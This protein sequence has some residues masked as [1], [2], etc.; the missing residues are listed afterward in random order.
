M[1]TPMVSVIIPTFGRLNLLRRAIRSVFSQSYQNFEIIIVDDGPMNNYKSLF[2]EFCDKRLQYFNRRRKGGVASAR[3]FGIKVSSGEFIAFLDDDDEWLPSK[4]EKQVALLQK[5]N[6]R[7]GIVHTNCYI[8]NGQEL[9][10]F[11]RRYL[12]DQSFEKLLEHDFIANSTCLIRREC[13]DVVGYFDEKIPY[14]EDWEFFIRAS[15][16]C[17]FAYIHQPLAILHW[18]NEDSERLS[19]DLQKTA[20]GHEYL[21]FKHWQEYEKYP[22]I[23]ARQLCIIGM[24]M[25]SIGERKLAQWCLSKA[26]TVFPICFPSALFFYTQII[27]SKRLRSKLPAK[28]RALSKTF[29][30]FLLIK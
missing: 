26:F 14:A 5:N 13:F 11:H 9:L 18:K 2:N 28:L 17:N 27:T 16:R 15:R 23:L 6:N 20:R 29:D 25:D 3:N 8:D 22:K 10:V 1:Y 4:L 30:E 12:L 19:D 21:V 7:V 24:K